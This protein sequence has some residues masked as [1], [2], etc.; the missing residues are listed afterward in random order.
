M[1]E[2]FAFCASGLFGASDV[3]R[4]R[5]RSVRKLVGEDD[6]ER[7]AEKKKEKKKRCV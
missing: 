7:R 4:L 3:L 6:N 5:E 2:G 1:I